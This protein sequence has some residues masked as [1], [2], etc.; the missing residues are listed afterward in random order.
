LVLHE[1][2]DTALKKLEG[3]LGP[4]TALPDKGREIVGRLAVGT[5][6]QR[7]CTHAIET[8]ESMLNGA[9]TADSHIRS[10]CPA[11]PFSNHHMPVIGMNVYA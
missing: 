3:E 5:E 6:V 11:F 7:L 4:I 8:L 9:L 1:V 2:V 10:K